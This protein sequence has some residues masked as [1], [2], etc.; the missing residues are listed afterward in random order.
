MNTYG[1]IDLIGTRDM[2]TNIISYLQ[3]RILLFRPILALLLTSE[4]HGLDSANGEYETSLSRDMGIPCAQ[5]CINSAIAMIDLVWA[6]RKENFPHFSI[7]AL[8]A[9][10]FQTFCEFIHLFT[11]F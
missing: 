7:E 8:P 1:T 6:W 9:W 5:R 3:I 10:W 2:N 4:A 11:Y